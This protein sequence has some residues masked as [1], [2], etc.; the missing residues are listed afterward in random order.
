M[1]S[2]VGRVFGLMWLLAAIGLVGTA[3]GL[4]TQLPWWPV[5][6]VVAFA[7]SLVVIVPSWITV[8]PGAKVG[9]VF[10]LIVL[11]ALLLPW[12]DQIIG[13]LR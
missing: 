8:P 12:R 3:L 4:A 6:A 5:L 2:G 10:D 7:V 13:A 1:H 9:A 11:V